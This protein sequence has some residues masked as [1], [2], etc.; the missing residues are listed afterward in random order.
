MLNA[1]LLLIVAMSSIQGGATVAKRIFPLV[2]PAGAL[3]I[4][5]PKKTKGRGSGRTYEGKNPFCDSRSSLNGGHG[6]DEK[7]NCIQHSMIIGL[8]EGMV[9]ISRLQDDTGSK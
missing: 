5:W 2:G 1:V 3:Q 4:S 8:D 9:K 7:K 6:N